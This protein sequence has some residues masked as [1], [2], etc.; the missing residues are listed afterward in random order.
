MRIRE[1]PDAGKALEGKIGA[2]CQPLFGTMRVWIDEIAFR[3]EHGL[4]LKAR[5]DP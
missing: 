5:S 4:S 1:M 2:V 3:H